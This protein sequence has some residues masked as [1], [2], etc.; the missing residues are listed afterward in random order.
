VDEGDG[1]KSV[2]DVA[3][4]F[5]GPATA[6]GCSPFITGRGRWW[7]T[8]ATT[9]TPRMTFNGLLRMVALVKESSSE[10]VFV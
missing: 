4:E 6:F 10:T 7:K 9:K 1:E 8:A 3:W 5:E 2:L